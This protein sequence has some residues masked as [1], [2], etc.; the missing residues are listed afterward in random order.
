MFCIIPHAGIA[1]AGKCRERVFKHLPTDVSHIVYLATNHSPSDT[2]PRND[3]V[4]GTDDH[5]F[6]W[7][8][9]E[10][11]ERWPDTP[12]SVLMPVSAVLLD[13]KKA[14][15][16]LKELTKAS[17]LCIISADLSH[18]GTR[19]KSEFQEQPR[20]HKV[21]A[22]GPL[23]RA[24]TSQQQQQPWRSEWSKL[25]CAPANLQLGCAL[26]LQGT[27]VEYY[28]SVGIQS[29]KWVDRYAVLDPADQQPFVSY[30]GIVYKS[31]P[32]LM[33]VRLAL[34]VVKSA[35]LGVDLKMPAFSPWWHQDQGVFVGG[36]TPSNETRCSY[37]RFR[38]ILGK[39]IEDASRDCRR[40]ARVRWS[41]PMSREAIEEST[42]KVE[43]LSNEKKR[44]WS[45]PDISPA[46]EFGIILSDA[47]GRSA[48]FLPSV[49]KD[50]PS[51]T[52]EEL[53]GHLQKKAGASKWAFLDLYKT[54]S[55][56]SD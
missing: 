39:S 8:E 32:T 45:L 23:I 18:Y 35:Q 28:D 2:G 46:D 42:Y 51:W 21:V 55:F 40:D 50:N 17:G 37:G 14:A 48:T 10:L 36:K 41:R 5:S 4:D 19:Y 44:V 34:G 43:L 31:V 52:L 22:E 29:Q 6:Q 38:G 16:D 27:V 11:K 30:V 7:V 26:D 1:Y 49:W 25:T 54:T 9:P 3:L 56:W 53:L 12:I 47:K 20:L 33:S 15:A 24:L 13:S